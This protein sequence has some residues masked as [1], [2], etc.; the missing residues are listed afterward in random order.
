MN[1]S[2]KGINFLT[3]LYRAQ[4]MALPVALQLIRKSL[5][6][7]SRTQSNPI[8]ACLWAY[9][10]LEQLRVQTKWNHFAMKANI[11]RAALTTAYQELQLLKG[12]SS[13]A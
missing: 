1:R 8:F 6:K 9:V 4:D 12:I 10:K 5:A 11:Y 2:V 7:T 13:P 3:C